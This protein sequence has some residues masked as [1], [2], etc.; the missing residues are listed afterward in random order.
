MSDWNSRL[1]EFDKRLLAQLGIYWL[2]DDH[3]PITK[4]LGNGDFVKRFEDMKGFNKSSVS[5]LASI[6]QMEVY[7]RK[8]GPDGDGQRKGL[9][10]QWYSW[11][12]TRFAQLFSAQLAELG[13]K[14][15]LEGFDGTGWSG[16]L[17]T[18]YAKLVNNEGVTYWDLWVEDTSRMLEQFWQTLFKGCYIIVAVEK[19]SLFA[20]FKAAAHAIGA[21]TVLS[22]KGKMSKAA[23][24]KV[25][26]E[27]F[28]WRPTYN[29][30]AEENEPMIVLHIS[31]HDFD[32]EAVIGPTFGEQAR[33]YVNDGQNKDLV[34]EA[35]VGIKPDAVDDWQSDWYEVKT[36][37][38]G[39][40]SW[41]ETEGLFLIECP[42]CG[43]KWTEKGVGPHICECGIETALSVMLN[44]SDVL[45][46]P[47]G[48][49]VEA[50]P[51]RAYYKMMV[52]A[53]LEVLPFDYIVSKLRDECQASAR[54]AA[55]QVKKEILDKNENYQALLREFDRLEE[56]KEEFENKIQDA[57]REIGTPHIGD[58][59]DDDDD[60]ESE[61]FENYVQKATDYTGPWRPFNSTA[62]TA[63][64]AEWLKAPYTKL[65][66]DTMAVVLQLI[67]E[68]TTLISMDVIKNFEQEEIEW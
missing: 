68:P 1:N 28:G 60:P 7:D 52:N 5:R 17:S 2:P 8:G 38:K 27:H 33:R 50:L 47:Y 64:L 62:R 4:A 37:N 56:I 49:E 29:P 15:E 53:L 9:R 46:Q 55:E 19:D 30:F 63:K 42:A 59:R 24:E 12:K 10:R 25:L 48:F 51:T 13:D 14:K 22:G 45:N 35:R 11:F 26:R 43:Y 58:W 67:W 44:K 66:D 61:D 16:R 20:D 65:D 40:V 31:D 41:A 54:D 57:L 34:L 21:R 6:C 23:T 18:V 3:N 39:Y 32:G 36:N